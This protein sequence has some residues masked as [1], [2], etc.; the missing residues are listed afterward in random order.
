M[1]RLLYIIGLLLLG[2]VLAVMIINR[3]SPDMTNRQKILRAFYPVLTAL[4]RRKAAM[5]QAPSGVKPV[6]S[7]YDLSVSLIDGSTLPLATL[8][9]KKIMF[10]NTASDCGYTGQYDQLQA[11]HEKDTSLVIIGFPA[12]DFKE[13]EKGDDHEIAAFCRRNYGVTFPLAKKSVVVKGNGQN[14]IFHWLSDRHLNGWNN[15]Q[16]SWNFSKYI[17]DEQGNLVWYIDPS[18]TPG[19]SE[20][21]KA[22]P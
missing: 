11:L 19:S 14:P 17:V 20:F 18:I 21:Q 6:K 9:G 3:N 1:K 13:Q 2:F 4:T 8:K 15:K 12:N 10:V 16:P 5:F 7:I 22:L